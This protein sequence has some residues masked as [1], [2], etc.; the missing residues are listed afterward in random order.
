MKRAREG[1]IWKRDN[2]E[3]N[4]A[5]GALGAG[6]LVGAGTAAAIKLKAKPKASLPKGFADF[7][8][9]TVKLD[10]VKLDRVE[11][12]KPDL[13]VSPINISRQRRTSAKKVEAAV[14]DL[15]PKPAVPNVKPMSVEQIK[16]ARATENQK[17]AAQ[18]IDRKKRQK[19][20]HAKD[21][22]ENNAR[23]VTPLD[24]GPN[25]TLRDNIPWGMSIFGKSFVKVGGKVVTMTPAQMK[26]KGLRPAK[27]KK[28]QG[29]TA[30]DQRI[31]RDVS[32]SWQQVKRIAD[33]K[34]DPFEAITS[35]M[36][37]PKT[38]SKA[39]RRTIKHGDVSLSSPFQNFS[40]TAA[41]PVK[42]GMQVGSQRQAPG[43]VAVNRRLKPWQ[44]KDYKKHELQH[45]SVRKPMS[46]DVRFQ[47]HPEK[48]W[49]DEARADSVMS[50]KSQKRS[51]YNI[52]A[53]LGFIPAP[54]GTVPARYTEGFKNGGRQKYKDVQAKIR[55]VHGKQAPGKHTKRNIAIIGTGAGVGAGGAT[56]AYLYNQ[57]RKKNG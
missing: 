57:N 19:E 10:K 27:H 31:A 12:D 1:G 56:G 46:R 42:N 18:R 32:A 16:Q 23:F 44:Q 6:A 37:P 38:R 45:V 22:A 25:G 7:K 53:K 11:L 29:V 2:T 54:P 30:E 20:Q 36:S 43:I 4:I 5:L 48:L 33:K 21:A 34:L 52:S 41:L 55:Q 47:R 8:L 26:A 17:A 14:P 15:V 35:P 28:M 40:A 9:D 50:R 39:G 13:E 3:R 49:G 51:L 24:K